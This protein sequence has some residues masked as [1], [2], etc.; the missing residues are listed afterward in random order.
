MGLVNTLQEKA[1]HLETGQRVFP[2][3]LG[4]EAVLDTLL[5]RA[6][7]RINNAA[8]KYPDA[9]GGAS[10]EAGKA[11]A[12]VPVPGLSSSKSDR[13]RELKARMLCVCL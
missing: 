2:G 11:A 13:R 1:Y 8:A 6:E 12:G 9:A 4:Q 5:T 10:A 7:E 3:P